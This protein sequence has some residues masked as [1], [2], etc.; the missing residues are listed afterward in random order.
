M[1]V[2]GVI[3]RTGR[4]V[5]GKLLLR[6]YRVR[7]LVRNLYSS[8]LDVIGT[9]VEFVK[10]DL[11]DYDSLFDAAADIGKV[12]FPAEIEN[13]GRAEMSGVRTLIRALQDARVADFG[14]A[15][16]TK[17]SLFH[18][19]NPKDVSRWAAMPSTETGTGDR[20]HR[21]Q[22]MKTASGCTAFMGQVYAKS[23]GFAEARCA[24]A[25][26]DLSKFSGLILRCVGDGNRYTVVVRTAAA[27]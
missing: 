1:L 23:V 10:G 8:K 15:E 4:I 5:L 12:V 9:G 19:S 16:A 22:F 26:I 14:V 20:A 18:F 6:G 7:V 11:S 3:G 24:P 27:A 13:G 2:I 21:V 25:Q 17:R